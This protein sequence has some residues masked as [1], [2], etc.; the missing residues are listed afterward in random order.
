M[1]VGRRDLLFGTTQFDQ[2]TILED[3]NAVV[4]DNAFETMCDADNDTIM[5]GCADDV[6]DHRVGF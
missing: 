1:K 2:L 6:L 3:D 4:V 5:E